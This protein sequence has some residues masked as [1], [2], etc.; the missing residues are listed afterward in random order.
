MT[1]EILYPNFEVVQNAN[2]E[3]KDLIEMNNINEKRGKSYATL[4]PMKDIG[5]TVIIE[6]R[7]SDILEANYGHIALIASFSLLLFISFSL[8]VFYIRESFLLSKTEKLLEMEK[9][10]REKDEIYRTFINSTSDIVFL[11]DEE[12]KHIIVN[13]A[14]LNFFGMKA[15]DVIGK[16]DFELQPDIVAKS[17]RQTDKKAL[18]YGTILVS[19]EL[20]GNKMY[21]T[22]KFPVRLTKDKVGVGGYVR[23][24]T[25]RKLIEEALK[26][27]E[28]KYRSIFDNAVEGIFQTTPE[29][30]YISANPSLVGM[31]GYDS[32]GELIKTV[33]DL[34]KQGYV[35]SE[36]RAI[37]KNTL[38]KQ[39]FILGFETQ[40]YRKD[41]SKIW[42]SIN[43]RVVKD[44]ANNVLYYEGTVEDITK[45]KEAEDKLSHSVENL[46]KAMGATIQL[47]A[48]VAESKDPYT[49]GHQKRVSNLARAIASEMNLPSNVTDGIRMA[50]AIHDIGKI[51]VP[52]EILSKPG[53]LSN[54]EF[55]LIKTHVQTGYD[56]L[57]DVVFPWPIAT[58]VFQHHERIDGSGYPQG[59][60]GGQ[61]LIEARII[62]VADVVEAIATHRPYREGLGMDAALDEIEK[63]RGVLYDGEVVNVCLKL[64]REKGFVLE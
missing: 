11:K 59:L 3:Q 37:F 1:E 44:E 15:E 42:I 17:C 36:D 26:A 7:K 58:I 22:R 50:G 8:F 33:A 18:E 21:E 38:E 12:L 52:A 64:F 46:R 30:R 20:I 23:D 5:W 45:R 16:T 25:E 55:S 35:N 51:S 9:N 4:A 62:S 28:E 63:N 32:P 34:S 2:G 53:V 41:G 54:I 19:E 49:A 10:L 48:Q 6:R 24:V 56:I 40:H 57:K 29:G 43:A 60:K 27:S 31:F 14:L 39:G 61:I 13:D 47:I